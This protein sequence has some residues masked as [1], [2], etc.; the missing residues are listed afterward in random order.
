[1]VLT[2]ILTGMDIRSDCGAMVLYLPVGCVDLLEEAKAKIHRHQ[3]VHNVPKGQYDIA[4]SRGEKV[5]IA[6]EKRYIDIQ[7]ERDD[8]H[9]ENQ[10]FPE[11]VKQSI[12][13]DAEIT[14]RLAEA[15]VTGLHTTRQCAGVK[16]YELVHRV[17]NSVELH[18]LGDL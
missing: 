11:V 12:R 13:I 8:N 14:I 18:R 4:G 15:S 6:L 3:N 7:E 17:S 10:P 5:I 16:L 2:F 9:D 1:M